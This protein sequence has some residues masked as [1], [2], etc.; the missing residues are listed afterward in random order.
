MSWDNTILSVLV[1][2]TTPPQR[3]TSSAESVKSDCSPPPEP[4]NDP[5]PEQTASENDLT[6]VEGDKI[7]EAS[8]P[9]M[10]PVESQKP[11]EVVADEGKCASSYT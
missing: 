4:S 5:P 9:T 2:T 6:G 8:S 7:N 10:Q 11:Q 1:S 3:S